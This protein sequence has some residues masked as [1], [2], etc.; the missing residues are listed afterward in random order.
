MI[1]TRGRSANAGSRWRQRR[2][3][4]LCSLVEWCGDLPTPHSMF[5]VAYLVLGWTTLPKIVEGNICR[6]PLEFRCKSMGSWVFRKNKPLNVILINWIPR[7]RSDGILYQ[8]KINLVGKTLS[9]V[10]SLKSLLSPSFATWIDIGPFQPEPPEPVSLTPRMKMWRM[11]R[12]ARQ[13]R[14]CA[15]WF[16]GCPGRSGKLGVQLGDYDRV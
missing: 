3:C 11:P 13:L 16:E 4:A 14:T 5:L 12:V 1:Y 9:H 10:E 6:K 8:I 15:N 2:H 7:S